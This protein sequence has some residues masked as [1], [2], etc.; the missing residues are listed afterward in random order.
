MRCVVVRGRLTL[1]AIA[2]ALFVLPALVLLPGTAMAARLVGGHEQRLVARAFTALHT[3]RQIVSI[4]AS[5]VAPSWVVVT[6]V[7]PEASGR[8]TAAA[9]SADLHRTYFHLVGGHARPGSPPR[10]ARADLARP[11]Q[12]ALVYRGAGTETVSYSQL[13]RSVCAGA[14]GFTDQQQET[15]SPMS[16][17]VRYVVD[18]DS[19]I[20]AAESPEGATILPAVTFDAP[21][22]R[23]NAIEKLTRTYV[24]Q[25]CFNA[26][27][28]YSCNTIFH[29]SEPGADSDLGFDPGLGTEV[30]IPMAGRSSGQC[31]PDDYTVGP[32]LWDGGATTAVV[33]Q[34]GQLGLLGT[35]LPGNPYAPI[36][37]SWP[38]N[39]A[40]AQEGFLVSPCQGIPSSCTDLLSWHGTVQL[41]AVSGG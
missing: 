5:T 30:G 28:N 34:L 12:V 4:R 23:L 21:A 7:T 25:G 8:T 15:V 41:Q 22:S 14:G 18:L 11:F 31:S 19:V 16:W 35:Q 10:G 33:G 17:S 29:L 37:V 26:P 2:A 6:S 40:V 9:H 24:D 32:S 3:Q 36:P 27:K 13:Y 1:S 20:E 39:S 38:T